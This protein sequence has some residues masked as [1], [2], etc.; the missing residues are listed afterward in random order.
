M[1][2]IIIILAAVFLLSSCDTALDSKPAAQVSDVSFWKTE[3]DALSGVS[4]IYDVMQRD[5]H[6]Y[7]WS[8]FTDGITPNGWIWSDAGLNYA[9]ISK[10]T[11]TPALGGAI[12]DKWRS[13]YKGIFRANLALENLP[14]VTMNATLKARLMAEARF[15]RA[16]FYYQL[17][18]YYGAVP[19][20]ETNLKLG[21]PLPNKNT[22]TE[23]VNFIVSECTA[24]QG[25]LSPSYTGTNIGRATSGAAMTLKA[26]ALLLVGNYNDAAIAAKQVIDLN[27]YGIY[28]N[29]ESMFTTTAAEN[30]NEVIFDVQY[31]AGMTEGSPIDGRFA[32][33]SSFSRGWNAVFPTRE[34]VDS[35]EMTNGKLITDPT[36]GYDPANPYANRDPRMDATIV[37]P[38]GSWRGIPYASISLDGGAST[39]LGYILRKH[40]ITTD[41]TRDDSPLN[42]IVFRYA[43]VLLMYAEAKN[44]VSGPDLTVYDALNRV[45]TRPGVNLPVI[46]GKTKDELRTIIR[47]ERQIELAFEGIYYTDIRRW[48]IAKDLMNGKV[49]RS[50]TN[51]QL[52][53]RNFI[54]AFYLW[55]I[56]QAEKDLSPSLGQNTGYTN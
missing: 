48:G 4:A 32:P 25:L 55:P 42:F 28:N 9:Q 53:T 33:L 44:E 38:G 45:R 22:R 27:L 12:V 31:A 14:N 52:D 1:K 11:H 24:I 49:I 3:T 21:A 13:L 19:I 8:I 2:R 20:L 17:A 30:N 35:Y 5:F 18:D 43:D 39:K 15:L 46:S 47:H 10:G 7:A 23:V 26:K 56:P 29:Y 41:A 37:R 54:D 50:L 34:F 40:A 16:L 36:S 51:T 6:I